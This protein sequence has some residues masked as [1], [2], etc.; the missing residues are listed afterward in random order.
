[1]PAA[2]AQR[3]FADNAKAAARGAAIIPAVA[4]AAAAAYVASAPRIWRVRRE[5]EARENASL[6]PTRK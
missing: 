4:A 1:L 2:V 5:A 3:T 6:T